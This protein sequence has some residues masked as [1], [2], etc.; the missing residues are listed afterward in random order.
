M[1]PAGP[2]GTAGI[3]GGAQL[4][5]PNWLNLFRHRTGFPAVYPFRCR[6]GRTN[7][8]AVARHQL[9]GHWLIYSVTSSFRIQPRASPLTA[10]LSLSDM[11]LLTSAAGTCPQIA[12]SLRTGCKAVYH[13][14]LVCDVSLLGPEKRRWDCTARM[15]I[16]S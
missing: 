15:Q 3:L 12:G 11:R 5:R 10:T 1:A 8:A 7:L 14:P 9:L 4:E 16:P 6:T 2:T 13:C